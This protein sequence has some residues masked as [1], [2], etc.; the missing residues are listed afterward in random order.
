MLP[1]FSPDCCLSTSPRCVCHLSATTLLYRVSSRLAFQGLKVQA[2]SSLDRC[3]RKCQDE[4]DHMI[5]LVHP[6]FG[7]EFR[8]L[9]IRTICRYS[10]YLRSTCCFS[11]CKCV[12]SAPGCSSD[13][14]DPIRCL[15]SGEAAHDTS[16]TQEPAEADETDNRQESSGV[17]QDLEEPSSSV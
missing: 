11:P 17:K 12:D 14:E 16:P 6:F 9:F 4:E 1:V 2:T 3:K 13:E 5:Q 7:G 15:S 10:S 8:A